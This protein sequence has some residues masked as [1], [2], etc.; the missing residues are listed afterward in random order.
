MCGRYGFHETHAKL[1]EALQLTEPPPPTPERYNIAPTQ[2][3][4]V[5]VQEG[6]RRSLGSWRWGISVKR[7]GRS[8]LTVFNVRS[9]TLLTNGLWR[10][11]LLKARLVAPASHFYEWVQQPGAQA[12]TPLLIRRRDGRPLCIAALAG[13][14]DH[15][16]GGRAFTLITTSAAP[17]LTHL[18]SRWPAVLDEDSLDVW[19]D[20]TTSLEALAEL[21]TPAPA[22]WFE[23]FAVGTGVNSVANDSPALALPVVGERSSGC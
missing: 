2:T 13:H 6:A 9:D 17:G 21:L 16:P 3:V 4:P 19:L 20:P 7:E 10:S 23:H 1:R 5:V 11:R 18:H 14:S 22:G 8:P 12:K 15:E